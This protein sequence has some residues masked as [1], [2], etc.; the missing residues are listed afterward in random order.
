M[1]FYD[2]YL[3]P[4]L[5]HLTCGQVPTM[6]QR[7]KVVPLAEGRV[8]EI[9]IGTGLNIPFYD[10]T[11]V[12]HLWGLDPSSEMWSIAQKNAT[13]HHL[14][15]EFIQSGAETIPL[16]DN[17]ADTVLMTYTMCTVPDIHA[18]LDEVRRVLRHDGRLIYCE[19]GSAPDAGVR[20]WQD[21]LNPVWKKL[22]GGCNLNRCIPE[23]LEQSGFK[24]PDMKTMYLPGWKPAAFNYW[25]TARYD[26]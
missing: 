4:R 3:L 21:R 11:R 5:V 26:S 18:A 7:Q 22:A 9:G 2:K 6:R 10:A 20:R 14:D 23:I 24:S 13:E 15:A 17:S 1:G 19:H 12:E 25:G 8:L 16:D